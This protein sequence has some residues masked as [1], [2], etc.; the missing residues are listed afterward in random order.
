MASPPD[1]T[2]EVS[3]QSEKLNIDAVLE[4]TQ[5][6]REKRQAKAKEEELDTRLQSYERHLQLLKGKREAVEEQMK[7]L[8]ARQRQLVEEEDQFISKRHEL[9]TDQKKAKDAQTDIRQKMLQ[10]KHMHGNFEFDN[11][12]EAKTMFREAVEDGDAAVVKVIVYTG[13]LKE[14]EWIPLITASSRGDVDM[15]RILLLAGAEADSKD[16]VFGRTALSW[17]SAGGHMAVAE[18]LLQMAADV[19]SQD[20]DGWTPLRRASERGHEDVVRLLLEKGAKIGCRKTLGSYSESVGALAVSPDAKLLASGLHDGFIEV[21]DT[22]TGQ[23][24]QT[25][26]HLP[27]TKSPLRSGRPPQARTEMKNMICSIVFTHDSMLV[28]SGSADGSVRVWDRATGDCQQTLQGHT[29]LVHAL[30][31]SHD[32]KLIVS[33]SNDKTIKIW[34]SATGNCRRTLQGHDGCVYRVVFSHDSR[35]I[36]SGAFDGHVKI[37]NRATGE[38]L[39]TLRGWQEEEVLALAFSHDSTRIASGANMDTIKIWDVTTG[40]CQ[41]RMRSHDIDVDSVAF[42]PDSKMLVSRSSMNVIHVWDTTTGEC[43]RVLKGPDDFCGKM[44]WSKDL[45]FVASS[46]SDK[47]TRRIETV[48][49]WDNLVLSS[50]VCPSGKQVEGDE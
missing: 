18:F 43:V 15:V 2:K 11:C 14:H 39:R 40:Q 10:L 12:D 46:S 4:F 22:E 35:L 32:S 3:A 20:N 23:C 44:A 37:W 21:W 34:E 41:L 47:G 36:A 26:Q 30:A 48:K 31:S 42:S 1:T 28:I 33:G 19:N 50:V 7:E 24:I 17:A 25:L 29:T 16:I 38:C 5:L 9:F 45:K 8:E 27:G 49:L 6:L 13:T